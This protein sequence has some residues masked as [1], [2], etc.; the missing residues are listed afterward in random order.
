[1]PKS[2][3]RDQS[4]I[5]TIKKTMIVVTARDSER[6]LQVYLNSNIIPQKVED[7]LAEGQ[8]RPPIQIETEL[9]T[10]LATVPC[11]MYT[12]EEK[13]CI[14]GFLKSIGFKPAHFTYPN[15]LPTFEAIIQSV[16]DQEDSILD[17]QFEKTVSVERV[18]NFT[19]DAHPHDRFTGLELKT[20]GEF[21]TNDDVLTASDRKAWMKLYGSKLPKQ[22]STEIEFTDEI[23]NKLGE[24]L[25]FNMDPVK[26]AEWIQRWA[27]PGIDLSK[28]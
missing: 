10:E 2:L 21:L 25:C 24:H 18:W 9:T 11:P 6:S 13:K 17:C 28:E 20:F 16:E 8:N 19:S 7:I 12:A 15:D 1:M 3:T 23:M 22:K 4:P 26:K 5:R 14:L 27:K